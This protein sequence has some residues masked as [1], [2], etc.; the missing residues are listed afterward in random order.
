[1]STNWIFCHIENKH[2]SCRE[3]DCMKKF[4]ESLK[5][6]VKNVIDF[7]RKKMLQLT[8]E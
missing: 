8:K 6:H 3:K 5:E 1:M 2:T 4:C 7:A